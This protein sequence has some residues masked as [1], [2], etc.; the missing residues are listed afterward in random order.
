[1][2]GKSRAGCV[3]VSEVRNVVEIGSVFVSKFD[4]SVVIRMYRQKMRKRGNIKKG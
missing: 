4:S 2:G 3:V 1:M